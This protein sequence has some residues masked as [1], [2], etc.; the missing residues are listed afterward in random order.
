MDG[1][2]FTRRKSGRSYLDKP[3]EQ[4]A[5]ERIFARIRWSPSCSNNQ[6]WRMVFVIDEGRK[7]ALAS[8]L[9]RGNNWA[10][11]AP[12][13]VAVCARKA[14]D[15]T[16]EDDPVEYH[17]F[18]CGLATMTL[19]LAAVEEGLMGHPMAGYSAPADST[20]WP[21]SERTNNGTTRKLETAAVV[22]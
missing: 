16:R 3:I 12:V 9:A 19:L 20:G 17:Q 11:K 7:D 8:A 18:D 13:L 6:P 15:Y 10:V 14:D 4:D 2:V 21:P 5:L 1:S 22:P